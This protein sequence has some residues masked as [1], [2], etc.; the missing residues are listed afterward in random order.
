VRESLRANEYV[1]VT[2]LKDFEKFVATLI[3]SVAAK[4]N[5]FIRPQWRLVI[6]ST[7]LCG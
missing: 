7:Q 3:Y 2:G 6:D 4:G 5:R 1:S